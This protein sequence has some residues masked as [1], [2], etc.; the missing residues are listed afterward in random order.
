LSTPLCGARQHDAI[1]L[2]WT[3]AQHIARKFALYGTANVNVFG[4]DDA[5]VPSCADSVILSA[6]VQPQRIFRRCVSMVATKGEYVIDARGLNYS[7]QD[8]GA[9]R[10]RDADRQ[11]D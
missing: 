5:R 11:R 8:V 2:S 1:G 9:E 6:V 3:R 4:L 10:A 7:V